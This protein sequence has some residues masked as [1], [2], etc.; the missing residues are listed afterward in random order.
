MFFARHDFCSIFRC[1]GNF[2]PKLNKLLKIGLLIF[3]SLT[4]AFAQ[5]NVRLVNKMETDFNNYA[6]QNVINTGEYL[7]DIDKGIDSEIEKDVLKKLAYAHYFT[8]NYVRAE[9]YF[10][11]ALNKKS[12]LNQDSELLLRYAQVLSANGKHA[13]SSDAW[14]AYSQLAE[15]NQVAQ[16]FALIQDDPEPLIRNVGSYSIDYLPFNSSYAEFS[17]V[18]FKDG[19]VFVSGRPVFNGVKRI[20]Q[21]NDSPFLDLYFL[22]D[23]NKIFQD[24]GSGLSGGDLSEKRFKQLGSDSYTP[25][26]ANDGPTLSYK[27]TTGFMEK[28]KLDA[29]RIDRTLNSIYHEGPCVFFNDDESIVFTRNGVGSLSYENPDG[30]N[31]VHL[32]MADK[33]GDKWV[34][35]RAFPYN[36]GD[37]STGHPAFVALENIMFFVSDMPGGYGGTDIYYSKYLDGL[38]G[39]PVNAGESINTSGNEMFPFI[40]ENNQLYFASDGHP[41]LGGLDLFTVSLAMNGKPEGMVHN[42]GTPLN[43]K[44]DDFGILANDDFSSGYF[45][46]NRKHGDSDDDIYSFTRTGSKFGCRNVILTASEAGNGKVMPGLTFKYYVIGEPENSFEGILDVNGEANLCLEAEKEFYFEFDNKRVEQK[47]IYFSTHNLSDIRAS[48]LSVELKLSEFPQ[49]EKPKQV[50]PQVMARTT[51]TRFEN[52]YAGQITGKDNLPVSGVRVRFINKCT[53]ETIEVQTKSDGKYAFVRDKECDYEFIAMKAGFATNY[54]FIAREPEKKVIAKVRSILPKKE[55]SAA[56]ASSTSFFDP[57]IFRVGDVVKMDKIYYNADEFALS[58]EAAGNLDQLA[59]VLNKYP[60]M[61]IEVI[62]HTDS[63]GSAK[64]NLLISQKRADEVKKYIVSKGV[65]ANRVKAIGKGESSPVNNCGDGVQC[66]DAEY[67]RNRRTEFR[68]LQIERI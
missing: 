56:S 50:V 42:L 20:F 25:Q 45:S 7:L 26:T 16:D 12:D 4:G 27:A 18:N 66:T 47:K 61:V 22:D 24:N 57:D 31:R 11:E 1:K 10:R 44:W 8:K 60:D 5:K 21:W 52:Y 54:E 23:R 3:V 30:V 55:S 32:Y 64:D 6:Y 36:S 9:Q 33:V 58:G 65:N 63:R 19:L 35:L 48:K 40:D 17:P 15:N 14:R 43:S 46:S 34:N 13:E 49:E 59:S 39:K 41:G 29:R 53:G 28:P 38:W 68:I 37:Y 62:S 51:D 2:T 67:R